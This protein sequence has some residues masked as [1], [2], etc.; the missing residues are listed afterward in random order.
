MSRLSDFQKPATVAVD[1]KRMEANAKA[2]GSQMDW[3]STKINV[4]KSWGV[5]PFAEAEDLAKRCMAMDAQQILRNVRRRAA[6]IALDEA[7]DAVPSD[8][9]E[10]AEEDEDAEPEE[11]SAQRKQGGGC[12]KSYAGDT[13]WLTRKAHQ[14]FLRGER[15]AMPQEIRRALI[16][17]YS[18]VV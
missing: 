14:E 3:R 18:A 11:E 7:L 8:D 17:R 9:D 10:P 2:A 12:G 1:T 4:Q 15:Q 5:N 13:G 6:H 16:K